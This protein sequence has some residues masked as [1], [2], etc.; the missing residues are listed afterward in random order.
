[1][2]KGYVHLVNILDKSGSVDHVIDDMRGGFNT[3]LATQAAL[4][5]KTTVT[6]V[7]FNDCVSVL[8]DFSDIKN[9]TRLTADNYRAEGSTALNDALGITISSVGS[10]LAALPES[11]RPEQVIVYVNTDGFENASQDYTKAKVAEMIK[12]Q[13]DTY[14]WKF[15]FAGANLDAQ[16]E[17][18]SYNISNAAQYVQTSAGINNLSN[19]LAYSV[20]RARGL[21][22]ESSVNVLNTVSKDL[23][24]ESLEDYLEG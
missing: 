3:Y 1:M 16:A 10:K 5:E 24:L 13:E 15:I 12:H 23:D 8:D 6:T 14:K 21:S 4:G 17:S 20:L 19:S 18:A 2:K 9:A 22:Y 7:L 11:E